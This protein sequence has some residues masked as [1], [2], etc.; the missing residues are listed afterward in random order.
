MAS[1]VLPPG[2]PLAGKIIPSHVGGLTRILIG[3]ATRG[4]CL[5]CDKPDP[6]VTYTYAD[7]KVVRL[8]S[9]CDALWQEGAM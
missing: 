3:R 5:I 4:R 6:N 1:G 9:A 2:P 8:H 7:R